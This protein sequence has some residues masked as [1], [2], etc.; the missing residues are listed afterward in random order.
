MITIDCLTEPDFNWNR[1]LLG[2]PYGTIYQTKEIAKYFE[3]SAGYQ[4]SYLQFLDQ[5]GKIVG[6]LLLSK[7]KTLSNN[8]VKNFLKKISSKTSLYRWIYGPTI[9]DRDFESE[10]VNEL[11]VFLKKIKSPIYGSEHPLMSGLFSNTQNKF[12]L[13]Q[14]STFLIDLSLSENILLQKTNKTSVQKNIKR[15]LKKNIIVKEMKKSDLEYYYKMLSETKEKVGHKSLYEN[16]LFHWETLHPIGFTGFM[17]Y[18]DEIPI[19]GIMVSNFNNY[20][21]EWGIART[22]FDIQNRTYAHDL[23][24]WNIVQWGKKTK[25]D[26]YDL[27][28]INPYPTT[29]KE[30]GIL[31]Y[32]QKWG[33]NWIKYNLIRI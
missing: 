10:I 24:K 5:T 21:N 12:K 32:K 8:Y 9:F 25:A 22:K 6:Q 15:S 27:T 13:Q 28:G 7:Q 33:G 3:K 17:A 1:R 2:S 23:L 19:G 4:H 18:H 20:I 30:S 11:H 26:Y 31:R 29:S 14:W 16:L